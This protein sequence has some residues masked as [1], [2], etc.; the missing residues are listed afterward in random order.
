MAKIVINNVYSKIV[1]HLPDEVNDELYD[2]LAYEHQDARFIPSVKKKK[3]DGVFR[4]YYR[5]RGQQFYTGL[6]PFVRDVLDKHGVPRVTADLRHVPVQN[7]PDLKFISPP[8]YEERVYQTATVDRSL[9]FTRGVI[10]VSTGGGKTLIMSRLISEIKTAPFIFYVLTKDLLHQAYGV[11]S[12]TLNEPIGIIGDNR[13]E[14]KRINVCTIQT[15]VR[16]LHYAEKDFKIDEY[17]FDEEDVWDED[18]IITS[19]EKANMIKDLIVGAKGTFVD[20]CVTGDAVVHTEYGITR[21]DE[22]KSKKC[23]YALSYDGNNIVYKPISQ[24]MDKGEKDIL[25]IFFDTGDKI[26]CTGNHLIY[27]H[28]G[29][30]KVDSLI[31]GDTVLGVNFLSQLKTMSQPV[32]NTNWRRVTEINSVGVDNVYDISVEDTHC[33]FANGV[34]VHNCHHASAKTVVDVLKASSNAYWRYG[35][36]ATP[37]RESGDDILIQAMFGSKIVDISASHL[38]KNGYLIPPYVFIEPIESKTKYSSYGK[39]YKECI[40]CNDEFNNH[41]AETAKHLM[42]RGFSTLILVKQYNQGDYIKKLLPDIEFVTGKMSSKKR[43]QSIQDLKDKKKPGMI[44]TSLADEGLDIP[45]LDVAILAGGGASATRVNQRIGRTIRKDKDG[46]RDRS[47]V[48]V[49]DHYKAKHL[50]DHTKKIKKIMKG[51]PEFK[52]II[53]KGENYILDE[54]DEV[55]GN[56]HEST[57]LF[58]V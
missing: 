12:S 53:S 7:L 46:N 45:T 51:E 47:I 8:N 55:L 35:G 36:S 4:L 19:Q 26:K 27:T 21:L 20:E 24:W 52:V 40:S 10:G 16:A 32:C 14:I 54:I 39:V 23:R 37:Y 30:K 49:Y 6:Y 57:S 2:V 31:Q 44:A 38:I 5:N 29:W 43:K 48:I 17:K 58:D 13:C 1:G 42:D 33:F 56:P 50:K 25:E 34:L 3:W 15:A 9:D 18:K 11:M 28:L 41:V 22:I